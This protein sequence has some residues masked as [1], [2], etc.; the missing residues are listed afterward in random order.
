M[1]CPGSG[2][3]VPSPKFSQSSVRCIVCGNYQPI[4]WQTSPTA[5]DH[6]ASE[7][8]LVT[9]AVEAWKR[10]RQA[11]ASVERARE[12]LIERVGYLD[13]KQLAQYVNRTEVLRE[14]A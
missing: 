8:V 4:D 10:V 7:A 11:E 5:A 14:R 13:G 9:L 12:R 2:T 1:K 3:P 6:E